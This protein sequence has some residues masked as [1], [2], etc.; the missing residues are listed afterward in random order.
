[1]NPIN[2][3]NKQAKYNQR[4]WT[5]EQTDSNQRGGARK[6]MEKGEASS[7]NMYKGPMDEAKKGSIAG[8]RWGWVGRGKVA[9]GKWRQ[10]YLNNKKEKIEKNECKWDEEENNH[11][12]VPTYL[13]GVTNQHCNQGSKAQHRK[14]ILELQEKQSNY[15]DKCIVL[16]YV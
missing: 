12:D 10:L 6:I 1:M 3:T 16:K 8:G 4:H 15:W 13:L 14:Y 2:K 11:T 9:V 5:K 7:R